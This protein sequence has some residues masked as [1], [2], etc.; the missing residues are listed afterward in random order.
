MPKSKKR[1]KRTGVRAASP[2]PPQPKKASR[3]TVVRGV[4]GV[5]LVVAVAGLALAISI[6]GPDPVATRQAGSSSS[7][8]VAS[9]ANQLKPSSLAEL[10]S[11]SP[12]DLA[13]VDVARMN[14]LCAE[15]L[16]GSEKLDIEASLATLDR[17]AA[18]IKSETDRH[19]YRF[20]QNPA[21]FENSEGYFPHVDAEHGST[22]GLRR[23]LQSRPH[24]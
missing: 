1:S 6:S 12:D 14:L 22:T 24:I 5:G 19:L 10:L 15:G 3:W 7:L 4:A 8:S 20:H 11:L 9:D 2:K 17:W 13:R 18:H 21:E 23:S 16:P